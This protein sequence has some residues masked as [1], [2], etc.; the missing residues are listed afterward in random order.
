MFAS[1]SYKNGSLAVTNPPSNAHNIVFGLLWI[2][3]GILTVVGPFIFRS[4]KMNNYQ[5]MYYL[6]NWE[7]AQEQYEQN[8]NDYYENQYQNQYMNQYGDGNYQYQWEQMVGSYDVNQCKWYQ[9]NCFPYY[10]NENG[11]PEPMAGW[12]PSWFSGW[13]VTE[14]QREQ[15]MEDGETSGALVFTYVWQILMF[16]VILA[17][18]F[19]VIR[20]NRIVT[21]VTVA[22]VL[23]ANMCF[24]SM[25]MLA[26]GSIITDGEYIQKTGFYGQFPVLMFITN[27]WYVIF[28]IV[29]GV[30]LSIRG[31]FMHQENSSKD[32]E[33]DAS[34]QNY[35]SLDGESPP[36]TPARAPTL[37]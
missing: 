24:L 2:I 30:L 13:T 25:W 12:Y 17:Y 37:V 27:A 16:I 36:V 7:E 26:D 11:E 3:S 35:K 22:L 14:E 23:F 34:A 28:G 1:S 5:N 8:R 19:I 29:F 6:Y 4:M 10:I 15:M 18:G 33:A 31:H 21:G 32:K 20:Q 9:F